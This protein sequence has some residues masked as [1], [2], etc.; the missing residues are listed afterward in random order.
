MPFLAT[1]LPG[2]VGK[3]SPDKTPHYPAGSSL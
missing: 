3:I 2:F 1:V